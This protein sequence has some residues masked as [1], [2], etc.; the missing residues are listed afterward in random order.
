MSDV[1]HVIDRRA[2]LLA[3]AI[4][5]QVEVRA[6]MLNP[7][8]GKPP[9][10]DQVTTDEAFA[11]WSKYRYEP[12]GKAAISRMTPLQIAELDAWLTQEVNARQQAATPGPLVP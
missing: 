7:V 10:T 1:Q 8:G 4:L 3:E 9:F 5:H 2:D 11:F 6:A 12:Q